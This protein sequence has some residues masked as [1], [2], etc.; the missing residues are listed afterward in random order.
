MCVCE[1]VTVCVCVCVC[2]CVP[3][4]PLSLSVRPHVVS[5]NHSS[6]CELTLMGSHRSL[7]GIKTQNQ[8]FLLNDRNREKRDENTPRG[9]FSYRFIIVKSRLSLRSFSS[10]CTI[11]RNKN[12]HIELPSHKFI[13][14]W[15]SS[16]SDICLLIAC[17]CRFLLRSSGASDVS[18]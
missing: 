17:F 9:A 3:R 2:V 13:Y 4:V 16:Y 10:V 5:V 6:L 7:T 8:C 12:R 18:I 1:R 15:L 11:T 14:I